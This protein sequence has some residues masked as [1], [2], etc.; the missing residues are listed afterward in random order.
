MKFTRV[1]AFMALAGLA[2]SAFATNGY[3]AHGNGMKAKGMAGASTAS[4]D[5]AFGGANNP[6]SM[7]F[8]GNRLDLGV[9]LFSPIREASRT[10]SAGT[11]GPE[12]GRDFSSKSDSNYFL[13]PEFGYNKMVNPNLA[14]GVTVYGNGGMNTNYSG[15]AINSGVTGFCDAD[16]SGTPTPADIGL[17]NGLCG[18]GRLGVDL[19]Q[20]IVAPTA[21]FKVAPNHSIGISPLL[22]YQRF[23]AEGLQAF[24]VMNGAGGNLGYDDAFGYGVRVGY[25]G[26]ITPTVSIGAAYASQMKFDEFGKYAGLFAEQGG[27]DIPENYNLGVAWQATPVVKLALDYQRINY[28][29]INSV[30]N[31]VASPG[32]L[33]ANNGPG[34]GWDDMDVWKLGMEY[35]YTPKLTLRAGYSHTDSP[36]KGTN[37]A[38]CGAGSENCAEVMLNILAPAVIEDHVTLGFTYTLASGNE[39]TMA[40]MHA[41]KNDVSG[42]N[43]NFGGTDKIEMYQNSLGIQYS[44]KM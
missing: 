4:S 35:K 20:L 36:I 34:F 39:V 37:A 14:L 24:G 3:F 27:F 41:F 7:A 17:F 9:D 30:G 40:Y 16:G 13:I 31:P 43:P 42:Y 25:M 19:M 18:K 28:S 22:G 5:D 21:A 15:N 32:S 29:K 11:F 44:W 6:A 38:G 26:K 1:F 2:G 12:P 10:G 8:A 23:K 33:G